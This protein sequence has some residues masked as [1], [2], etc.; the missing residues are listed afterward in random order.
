VILEIQSRVGQ[1]DGRILGIERATE[2]LTA[3]VEKLT[4]AVL[5][6]MTPDRCAHLHLDLEKRLHQQIIDSCKQFESS[7]TGKAGLVARVIRDVLIIIA[8]L[9]GFSGLAAALGWLR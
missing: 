3:N 5:S 4:E 8:A 9:G 7:I 2:R 1:I 6:R